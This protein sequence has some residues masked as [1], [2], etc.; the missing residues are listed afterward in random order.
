M[1]ENGAGLVSMGVAGASSVDTV[2]PLAILNLKRAI[3]AAHVR[4]EENELATLQ[5]KL[6][7]GELDIVVARSDILFQN[8]EIHAESLYVEPVHVVAR[9]GHPLASVRQPSWEQLCGYGWALWAKGTPVRT[10][11]DLSLMD[12]GKRLPSHFIESNSASLNASILTGSDLLGIA[13]CRPALRLE[14]MN[15]LS[16]LDYPLSVGSAVTVYWRENSRT[17]N[18]VL[19]ALDGL[20]KAVRGTSTGEDL[21]V[22]AG[23]LAPD[24]VV[25]K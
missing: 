17:R 9:C 6:S 3:P 14:K 2:I 23:A 19:I 24:L 18:T 7:A 22:P 5:A 10:A 8:P 1:R 13:A 16:I 20:R 11:F 15:I 12:S 25:Q 4:I 21:L